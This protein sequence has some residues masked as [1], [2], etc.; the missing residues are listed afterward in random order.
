MS[1]KKVNKHNICN[2]YYDNVIKNFSKK[3]LFYIYNQNEFSYKFASYKVKKFLH[4]FLKHPKKKLNIVVYSDKSLE[5]YSLIQAIF[6]SNSVF[7]PISK[8]TPSNRIIDMLADLKIDYF[9]YDNFNDKK[10]L[11]VIK[12]RFKIKN[13]KTICKLSNP[14]ENKIINHIQNYDDVCMVYFT[15]G[16]TGTP[17]GTKLSHYNYIKDFF[18]QKKHL[19]DDKAEKYIFGDYHETSFSI[20]YDIYFPAVFFGSALSPAKT[21][22]EKTELIDH[23]RKNRVNVL[24]TVPSTLQRVSNLYKKFN[25]KKIFKIIII[26]GETFYLN[27]LKFLHDNFKS[28]KIFN[29]YGSTELSNWVFYHKCKLT[30]HKKF[31]KF[32]LVPIGKKFDDVII[33]IK[34]NILHIGGD[35]VSRGYLKKTQNKNKFYSKNN[36]NWYNTEDRILKYK[37]VYICKGRNKNIIK[38]FG[39]RI[40]LSDIESNLRKIKDINEAYCLKFESNFKELV[41][42]FVKAFDG[43]DEKKIQKQLTNYLPNYMIPKKIVALKKF[44]YNNNG[45]IDRSELNKSIKDLFK[46]TKYGT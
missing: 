21:F 2:L 13:I 15:S 7:I 24:I 40:D 12:K 26:T 34:N 18:L 37:D 44:P 32:N 3:N 6:L 14:S 38:I 20:F 43:F 45:K 28:K 17:K 9:F 1:L 29:C 19:Y 41:V 31:K 30:D 11:N 5:L 46:K 35:V 16:S 36:L 27:Q 8:N 10:T 23:I 42:A 33:K 4:F 22:F 25:L 39:Y